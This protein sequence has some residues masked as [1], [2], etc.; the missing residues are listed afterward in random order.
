MSTD[1]RERTVLKIPEGAVLTVT[2]V[3]PAT[4]VRS[5][6]FFHQQGKSDEKLWAHDELWNSSVSEKLKA[7]HRYIVEVD[8]DFLGPSEAVTATMSIADKNGVSLRTWSE[9]FTHEKPWTG[10]MQYVIST[11]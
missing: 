6:G 10:V 9:D 7:K 4:K 11:K 5:Q 1:F 8:L 2:L 3:S